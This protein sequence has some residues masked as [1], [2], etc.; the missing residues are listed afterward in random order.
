MSF[1]GSC[2]LPPEL[3]SRI[4]LS[5]LGLLPLLVTKPPFG[6]QSSNSRSD[7]RRLV[8]QCEMETRSMRVLHHMRELPMRRGAFWRPSSSSKYPA[9]TFFRFSREFSITCQS[10]RAATKPCS[11]QARNGSFVFS[12]GE[13]VPML[14]PD[15]AD[16]AKSSAVYGLQESLFG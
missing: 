13:I 10:S 12:V 3:A 4:G 6:L 7:C 2:I 9:R 16:L 8:G 14:N 15:L 5:T 1:T 11:G